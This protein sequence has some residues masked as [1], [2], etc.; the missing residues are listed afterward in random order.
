MHA[1]PSD[2]ELMGQPLSSGQDV[3]EFLEGKGSVVPSRAGVLNLWAV[4]LLGL[5][6]PFIG[7]S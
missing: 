1:T 6:D 2:Q 5:N 3:H 7:V 4:T